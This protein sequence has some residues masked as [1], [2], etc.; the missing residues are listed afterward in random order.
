MHTNHLGLRTIPQPAHVRRRA[1]L[2]AR[3][4]GFGVVAAVSVVLAQTP[5][6]LPTN[7]LKF[8][9]VSIRRNTSGALGSNGNNQRPDGG[10]TR[11]NG[12]I[13]TLIGQAYDVAAADMVGLPGWAMDMNQRYD[14]SATSPLRRATQEQ[15]Q[16]MMRAMLAERFKL[17]ARVEKRD[18][19]VYDLVL[20]R[21]DGR[22]GPGISPSTSDCD[23]ILAAQRAAAD[24]ALDR[25]TV[26]PR[27]LPDF[28]VTMPLCSF[29]MN[30]D[31]M[32]GEHTIAAMARLFRPAAGRLV[33]DKTGLAGTYK[34]SISFDR[35]ASPRGPDAAAPTPGAAPSLF[36]AVQEQL[37][38]R[39]ESSRAPLDVLVIERLDRPTEN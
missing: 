24:A 39:L 33:V 12:L 1:G 34:I 22:L 19:P 10:F 14:I 7:D 25:G 31:R 29:R 8:E 16:A 11:L 17:V 20:A 3:Q 30:G 21:P 26:P 2:F 35:T 9:V 4:T 18:Q 37:G 36:T 28:T 5:G 13:G 38:M 23:A 15:R 27:A 32:D 6:A